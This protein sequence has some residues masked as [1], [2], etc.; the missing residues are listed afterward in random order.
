ME[1]FALWY[2]FVFLLGLAVGSFLNVCVARLPY[3]KSLVWPGSHCPACLQPICWFDNIPVVSYLVLGGRC[4]SCRAPI[5]ARYLLIELGTGL[6]FVALFHA[7][8]VANVLGLPMLRQ[9]WGLAPGLVPPE[10]TVV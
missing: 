1:L 4:R 7:E 10:A 9:R 8:M 3:E 6:A 2:V 5:A